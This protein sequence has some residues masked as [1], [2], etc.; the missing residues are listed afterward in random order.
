MDGHIRLS[1]GNLI[2]IGGVAVLAVY[3][4]QAT[5]HV[6]SHKSIP[7]LS[8]TARGLVDFQQRMAA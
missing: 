4:L 1:L 2:V 5:T 3:A 6:L 8:P 7:V